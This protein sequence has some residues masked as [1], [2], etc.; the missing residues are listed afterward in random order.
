[1]VPGEERTLRRE[2]GARR[3]PAQSSGDHEVD[4]ERELLLQP[5]EQPLAQPPERH[6]APPLRRGDRRL[7]GPQHERLQDLDPLDR[8]PE[9]ARR[10]TLEVELEVGELGHEKALWAVG[11]EL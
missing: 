2:R 10:E 1:V 6:H 3:A 7:D 9:H 4:G 11:S 8:L 5:Q